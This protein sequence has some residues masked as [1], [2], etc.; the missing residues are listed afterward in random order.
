MATGHFLGKWMASATPPSHADSEYV[1]GSALK[2]P[3]FEWIEGQT[4]RHTSALYYI[5]KKMTLKKISSAENY[6]VLSQRKSD[7]K[8]SRKTQLKFD[9]KSEINY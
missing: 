6:S 9:F 5:D 2:C 4:D 1:I 7:F 3:Q 8:L